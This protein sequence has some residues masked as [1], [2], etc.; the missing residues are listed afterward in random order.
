[1]G[2][3]LQVSV[4]IGANNDVVMSLWPQVT[5]AG[6]YQS[7]N[8]AQYPVVT[9]REA[10]TTVHA[11]S[12]EM[13]AL[14]GLKQNVDSDERDGI[15]GLKDLPFLGKLFSTHARTRN[16]TDLVIFLT[17]HIEDDLDH[18]EHIPVTVTDPPPAG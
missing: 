13:V 6:P 7:Y 5:S 3:Y 18:V 12:G 14:G 11:F 10:Q 9:S 2:I 15:P 16:R 17:P 1:M 8:G 4:Q